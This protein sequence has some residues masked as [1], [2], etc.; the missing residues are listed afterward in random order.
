MIS[1]MVARLAAEAMPDACG[2]AAPM[3]NIAAALSCTAAAVK[4]VAGPETPSAGS[5]R[6]SPGAVSDGSFDPAAPLL[7]LVS[8][9]T[10]PDFEGK[11]SLEVDPSEFVSFST[12]SPHA[13]TSSPTK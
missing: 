4:Q 3:T 13:P 5:C 12:F 1:S 2:A 8:W 6:T 9:R 10:R 11:P 7:L